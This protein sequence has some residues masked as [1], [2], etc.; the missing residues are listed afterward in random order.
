MNEGH[1]RK[2]G[3]HGTK[4]LLIDGDKDLYMFVIRHIW[5][6]VLFPIPN[7]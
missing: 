3:V 2:Y 7:I 4:I 5:R 1:D 6:A